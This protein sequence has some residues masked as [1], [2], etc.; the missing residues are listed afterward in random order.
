MEHPKPVY[1]A[2]FNDIAGIKVPKGGSSCSSCK[3]LKD[4]EAKICGEPNFIHWN[5]GSDKI[6]GAIDAYCSIWW[7][8]REGGMRESYKEAKHGK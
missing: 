4:R 3:Y 2:K 5:F 7:E 6:P 8:P 1:P